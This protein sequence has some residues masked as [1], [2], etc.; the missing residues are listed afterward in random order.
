MRGDCLEARRVSGGEAIVS[1]RDDALEARA[2]SR[3]ETR[4]RR[5]ARRCKATRGLEARLGQGSRRDEGS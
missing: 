3:G 1:R 5:Q 4:V 2:R